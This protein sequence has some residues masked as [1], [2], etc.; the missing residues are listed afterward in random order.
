MRAGKLNRR[1]QIQSR[2]TTK[3]TFGEDAVTWLTV[4]TVWGS[5]E[6]LKGTEKWSAQQVVE[7]AAARIRM[8]YN[9]TITAQHRIK[10]AELGQFDVIGEPEQR[11][12]DGETVIHVSRVVE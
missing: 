5:W 12:R 9:T 6:P 8:R 3:N 11:R 7:T 2:Q 4:D 10:N 1:W